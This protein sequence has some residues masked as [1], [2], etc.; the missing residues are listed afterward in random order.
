MLLVRSGKITK[1]F[2]YIHHTSPPFSLT[3]PIKYH[4]GDSAEKSLESEDTNDQ[5]GTEYSN[6]VLARSAKF[7]H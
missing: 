2:Q 1:I 3:T 4:K 5:T 7:N 6:W